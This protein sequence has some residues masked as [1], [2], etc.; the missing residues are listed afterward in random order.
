MDAIL[1][2]GQF[3][4]L[5][6]ALK[7]TGLKKLLDGAGP[8]TLFA[9]TDE[10]FACLYSDILD[11]LFRDSI[12]LSDVLTHHVLPESITMNDAVNRKSIESES[13]Q[14]FDVRLVGGLD[15]SVF[16]GNVII[17][18]QAFLEKFPSS[19][20]SRLFLMDAAPHVRDRAAERL[21]RLMQDRGLDLV[22]A[23]GR[24]AEFNRVENTY[25]SIFLILGSLGLIF[26]SLGL[27]IVVRR[28][29][30]ERQGELALL[31]AG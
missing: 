3:K 31:R 5:R 16:Q 1:E 6:K 14:S 8:F 29:V 23:A 18:E 25:L 30:R 22:S 13:G 12:K 28:T 9:P 20:G 15:N 2:L 26:G 17:S 24:L 7:S 4:T 10:A 19:G 21:G 27:G 11:V